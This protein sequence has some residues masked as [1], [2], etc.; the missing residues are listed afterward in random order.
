[1]KG[2]EN[3]T[4]ELTLADVMEAVRRLERKVERVQKDICAV[5]VTMTDGEQRRMPWED[6]DRHKCAQV[7]KVFDCFR[8]RCHEE[9][10]TFNRAIDL[11]FEPDPLGYEKRSGLS[12]WC[13]RNRVESYA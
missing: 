12:S 10:F 8:E 1:M 5:L 2:T 3:G 6:L 13:Y 11:A 7:Q 4:G 9:G